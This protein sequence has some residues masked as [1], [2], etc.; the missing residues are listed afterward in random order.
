MHE[1]RSA[2]FK[3]VDRAADPRTYVSYLDQVTALE[4]A[5]A[6]KRQ[7]FALLGVRPGD[8]VLDVGC[9]TGDD[10]RQLADL[11]GSSGRAVG[12]DSSETMLQQARSRCAG[13]PVEC[14]LGDAAQLPFADGTFDACRADRVFQ[15]LE[16]PTQAL[17][18]LARVA[19]VG[20]RIVV[21]DPDWD[22]LVIDSADRELTRRIVAFRS[23]QVRNGWMGRQLARL[24]KQ[25]GLTDIIVH[26]FTGTF[27]EWP[28]A[29]RLFNLQETVE[30]AVDAHVISP[31]EAT[32]WV[33]DLA[34]RA[35]AG[36]FF[37]ALSGFALSGRRP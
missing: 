33:S 31:S 32:A 24:A 17:R 18:E 22:T 30:V 9:G 37:S 36:C 14:H 35:S 29:D 7:T 26:P 27:T 11:V 10:L 23:D 16:D 19:R 5:Q 8:A 25:C 20:A 12:L 4:G 13:L 6:Y 3:D 2:D 1:L 28:V 15:H 21:S 34:E